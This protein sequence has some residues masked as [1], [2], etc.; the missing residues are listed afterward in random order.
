M[1]FKKNPIVLSDNY[2]RFIDS[3][4]YSSPFHSNKYAEILNY[5]SSNYSI[6]YSVENSD[7]E[8]LALTAVTIQKEKGL[9]SF[10]SKRA[11][12]YSG[13]LLKNY[14]DITTLEF[15]LKNIQNELKNKVIYIEIRNFFDYNK[16]LNSYEKFN[17]EYIPYLNFQ[18]NLEN[19]SK[20]EILSKMKYNRKREIRLSLNEGALTD[21][22]LNDFE[23]KELYEIL[24]DLY[25]NRVKLPLPDLDFFIKLHHSEIGKT[26]VVKHQEK[27]IGGAFCIYLPNK[28]I[29]TLYYCG[30]RDYHKKIFPTHLAIIGVIEFGLAN[31][32][33]KLDFMGAGKK[34]EEYGVRKYK[35][36]FGGDLVEHGRFLKICKPNLF[37]LGKF[38]L[39]ML[40]KIK[41]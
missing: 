9:K 2:Q 3:N 37:K 14:S 41:K 30:I 22:A 7:N 35:E 18:L 28:S 23:V 8:V 11:I 38:A 32:L 39:K 1:Y 10:F 13:I 6:V 31:N 33:K 4:E 24:K 25:L 27:I 16:H 5:N 26:F 17:W 20:E 29:Y 36:E 40:Q 34:G 12:I 15:L 21:E 19:T